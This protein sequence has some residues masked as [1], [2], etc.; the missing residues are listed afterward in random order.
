MEGDPVAP[1]A[2]AV[3]GPDAMARMSTDLSPSNA[4]GRV[5]RAVLLACGAALFAFLIVS[6]GPG[7]IAES[8]RV[9]SWRLLVLIVFPCAVLKMLDA[10]AWRFAFPRDSVPLPR[11]LAS[12]LG[13]QAVS[14]TTPAGMLGGNAVMAWMLRDR[15]SL[16]ESLASLRRRVPARRQTPHTQ[17]K[18]ASR[19][20]MCHA[21]QSAVEACTDQHRSHETMA[22]A[23]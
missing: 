14:S 22:A 4:R 3:V 1:V 2:V 8:F 7:T 18:A 13:G 19:Q 16:R 9:L 6:I 21:W 10:L 11:L 20:L 23:T 15:V 17:A 12:L 5:Y